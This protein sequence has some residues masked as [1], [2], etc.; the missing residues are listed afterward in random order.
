MR[1]KRDS[2]VRSRTRFLPSVEGLDLRQLMAVTFSVLPIEA[3]ASPNSITVGTDNRLWFTVPGFGTGV[4]ESIG[5]IDVH[6]GV[7]S[8]YPTPVSNGVPSSIVSGPSGNLWFIDSNGTFNIAS[9]SPSTHAVSEFPVATPGAVPKSLAVGPDGNL[10]FTDTQNAAIGLFNT[11]T[12]AFTEFPL[13]NINDVPGHIAAG[14]DGHLW[15][16]L[17][18]QTAN[19]PAIGDINPTTHAITITDLPA[20]TSLPP[21]AI[22]A[23][24]DGNVWFTGIAGSLGTGFQT[25][26]GMISPATHAV[27]EFPGGGTGGITAG[28]DGNMWFNSPLGEINLTSHVVS[29]YTNV[30]GGVQVSDFGDPTIVTGPDGNIW[31]VSQGFLVAASIIPATQSALM[32]YLYL[33][34]TGVG[35]TSNPVAGQTVFLDVNRDGKVEPGEPTANTNSSGSY[36]FTGLAPGTYT[37]R[38]APYPGN[39]ATSPA[40][41]VQTITVTGGQLGTPGPLGMIPSSS[42]SPLSYNPMPFGAHNPDVQTAEVTGLYNLVLGRG[43][44]PAGLAYWVNNI[45]NGIPISTLSNYLLT[46]AEYDTDLILADYRN[47]LQVSN[48]T[49]AAVNEWVSFMQA[50]MSAKQVA[51]YFLTSNVFEDLHPT[52]LD[53]TQALY[54]DILGYQPASWETTNWLRALNQGVSRSQAVTSF[55]NSSFAYARVV[56]G[57]YGTILARPADPFSLTAYVDLLELGWTP[58]QVATLLFSTQEFLVR[59]N[60]TVG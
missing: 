28:P 30:P 52:D 59:A 4:T 16:T 57:L 55:L 15:F 56:T 2:A 27:N 26:I 32:G 8:Y 60:A 24:P 1:S 44:D 35:S 5:A 10:W 53:F 20:A 14:A 11:S 45:K 6:T 3:N 43:P 48:P 19:S 41:S 7:V 50:G 37:V 54:V 58:N 38:V 51:Y 25:Q 31:Q 40:S 49:V 9:I 46:S 34:A 13:P 33:D 17:S 18:D 21:A 42:L 22:A 23:G 29:T 12:H 36:M 39:I 47:F